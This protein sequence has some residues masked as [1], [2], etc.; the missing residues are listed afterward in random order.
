MR[1]A[2]C[3]SG[4]PLVHIGEAGWGDASTR[5]PTVLQIEP[6]CAHRMAHHDEL[7]FMFGHAELHTHVR[8]A[9][10]TALVE[11]IHTLRGGHRAMCR[12]FADGALVTAH[13]SEA[14][15]SPRL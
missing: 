9:V 7:H 2:L 15:L 8:S 5:V 4:S 3:V 11:W 1:N 6:S 10:I 14:R 13:M 12:A